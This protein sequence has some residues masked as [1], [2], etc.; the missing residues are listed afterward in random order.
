MERMGSGL[1]GLVW[2]LYILLLGEN[3]VMDYCG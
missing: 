2:C 3:S 1:L